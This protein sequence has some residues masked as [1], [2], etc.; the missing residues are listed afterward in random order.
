MT[1]HLIARHGNLFYEA[2]GSVFLDALGVIWTVGGFSATNV[3][4]LWETR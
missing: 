4:N 1:W 3:L 2:D